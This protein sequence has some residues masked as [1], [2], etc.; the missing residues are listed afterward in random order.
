[1]ARYDRIGSTYAST[2]REDPDLRRRLHEA[3]G[4]G[5]GVVV[6]VGAG[7]GSYEPSGRPVV[8]VEPSRTMLEQRSPTSA[9]AVQATAGAVPLL[10]GAAEAAMAV[11][12]IHHWD[13]QLAAGVAELR[14]VTTGPIAVVTYDAEVSAQMWLVA[15]YLPEAAALDRATFPPIARLVDLLAAPAASRTVSASAV[16]SSAVSSSA[17]PAAA[18]SVTPLPI[19]R[20]TPDWTMG[21]FWAHPERVLDPVARAGTS[22]F[23]RMDPAVVDRCVE[24]VERDLASGAWDDR[25]GRLRALDELDVGLRLVV[26]EPAQ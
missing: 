2:R 1:M 24:D 11:L 15:D 8:A 5:E 21:S 14:R 9:P 12:T 17:V 18:V 25:H 26:S 16:S 22:T 10:D 13:D 4:P 19:S 6:N 3:L 20:H 23:S 7:T